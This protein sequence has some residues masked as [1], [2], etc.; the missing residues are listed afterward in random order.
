M[1]GMKD[2][3]NK[4]KNWEKNLKKQQCIVKDIV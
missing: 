2:I 3:F 4:C 1:K